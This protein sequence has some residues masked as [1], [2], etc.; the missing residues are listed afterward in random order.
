MKMKKYIQL[1]VLTTLVVFATG[2]ANQL[3]VKPVAS[4]DA[5]A[6]LLTSKDVKGALVGAYS[7]M[8]ANDLYSGG[9]QVYS[10][11]VAFAN[12]FEVFGTFQ[13]LTQMNN[14]VILTNNASVAAVWLEAYATINTVNEVLNA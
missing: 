8:G 4:I 11:L 2:C 13:E 6:A 12:D 3:D 9:I 14:K 10:D 7:N 5:S 1:A